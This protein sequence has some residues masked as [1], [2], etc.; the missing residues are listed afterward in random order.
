L[1][2]TETGA[3]SN[4]VLYTYKKSQKNWG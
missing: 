2:I 4:R 1:R 3:A